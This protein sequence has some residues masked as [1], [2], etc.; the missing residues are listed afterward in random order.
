MT[1]QGHFSIAIPAYITK[2]PFG[3]DAAVKLH[4]RLLSTRNKWQ[5]SDSQ[6]AKI[7]G[8]IRW[9]QRRSLCW[10][11]F[12]IGFGMLEADHSPQQLTYRIESKVYS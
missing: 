9:T 8:R 4:L 2:L 6:T 1:I 10:R 5:C 7:I 3:A 12:V 11:R